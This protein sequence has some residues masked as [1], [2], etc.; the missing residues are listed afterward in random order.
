MRRTTK[1]ILATATLVC[2]A[3]SAQAADPFGTW[4]RPSTGSQI[5]FYDCGGKLCAKVI[6][7]KDQTK[8]DMVGK[9]IMTGAAK[10]GDNAW[11]GDLLN[12]EDGKTYSGVVT[13]VSPASL[14]LKGCAL[15]GL[16]C[17]DENLTK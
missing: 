5:S 1:Y 14:N 10:S 13:L 17:K 2:F 8:K 4:I 7:V 12:L 6:G 16:I 9:V 3:G 15:G 11:K